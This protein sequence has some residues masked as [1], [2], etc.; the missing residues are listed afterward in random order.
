MGLKSYFKGGKP[1]SEKKPAQHGQPEMSEKVLSPPAPS[2][3]STPYGMMS[4][5]ASLAPSTKST[6]LDEVKHEI[7]V[8]YLFQQQ[9]SRLWVGDASGELEGVLLRKYRGHYLGCPPTLVESVFAAGCASLNVQVR[10][11]S[12]SRQGQG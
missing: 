4:S 9:C 5:R 11:S 6:Y 12:M 1:S 10:V 3:M 8:N 2:G 7:M